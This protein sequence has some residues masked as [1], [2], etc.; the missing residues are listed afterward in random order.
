MT[1]IDQTLAERG[2]RYGT[3]GEHA[4]IAQNIKAAMVDSRNWNILSPDKKEALEMLAH[5]TARILNGDPEYHDSWHDI[6]GYTKLVADTL[7]P[8]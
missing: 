4:R 3:F 5:K 7:D 1:T 6:I 8:T 2:T